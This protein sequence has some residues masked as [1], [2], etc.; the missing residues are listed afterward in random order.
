MSD[1]VLAVKLEAL[2]TDVSEVKAALNKL[3][4]AI[5]KLA[6][7]EQQ[8]GQIATSLE[9]AFKAISKIEDRVTSLEQ[10]QAMAKPQQTE[11]AKWVDRGLVAALTAGT[12]LIGKSIG[13]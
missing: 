5:T 13:L 10:Q 4:D 1:D 7:V 11:M 3:S 8:Q 12:V 6:L 9:R 2:H